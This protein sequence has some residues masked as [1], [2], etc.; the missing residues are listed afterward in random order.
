VELVGPRNRSRTELCRGSPSDPLRLDVIHLERY[1]DATP[2]SLVRLPPIVIDDKHHLSPPVT[3][4][5]SSPPTL[6]IQW[7]PLTPQSKA[8]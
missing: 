6:D 3:T 2:S 1:K 7:T 8:W 4:C 5:H